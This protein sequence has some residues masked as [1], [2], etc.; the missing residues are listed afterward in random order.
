MKLLQKLRKSCNIVKDAGECQYYCRERAASVENIK[1]G[2]TDGN[3]CDP[4]L[5]ATQMGFL[6]RLEGFLQGCLRDLTVEVV[7]DCNR[8]LSSFLILITCRDFFNQ[9]VQG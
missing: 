1:R 9:F 8:C 2:G 4:S 3:R 5:G 7:E 6:A